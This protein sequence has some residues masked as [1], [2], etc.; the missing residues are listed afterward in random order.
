MPDASPETPSRFLPILEVLWKHRVRFV[1][2]GGR[3]EQLM[4]SP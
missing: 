1:V 4:G 2:I 3:A